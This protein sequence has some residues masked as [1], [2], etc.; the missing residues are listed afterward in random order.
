MMLLTKFDPAKDLRELEERLMSAFNM[1]AQSKGELA[2]I[3][4]FTPAVN[5]REG[6]FAYHIEVDL[7]GV[8]KKDIHVDLKDDVL[9]ISGERKIKNEVKKKDYYKMESS[10]GKFQRSFTLPDNADSENIKANCEEGMLE[11]VIPKL[12][13]IDKDVKKI[14]IK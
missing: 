4:G 13:K 5:T 8:N 2:N 11:V 12:K 1:P 14:E 10:Y 7:P 6:E 3:S 9:T